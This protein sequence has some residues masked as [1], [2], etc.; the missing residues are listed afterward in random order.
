MGANRMASVYKQ[1]REYAVTHRTYAALIMPDNTTSYASKTYYAL[2]N[3]AMWFASYRVAEVGNV[4]GS[5]QFIRWVEGEPW[6]KMP[7]G[8]A[9][10]SLA[11]SMNPVTGVDL[12]DIGDPAGT[13]DI[14]RCIVSAPSGGLVSYSVPTLTVQEATNDGAGNLIV[15]NAANKMAFSINPFTGGVKFNQ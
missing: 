15:T 7:V 1:V 5:Y 11:G 9:I 10:A 3:K 8:T 4:S 12:H 6:Q 2:N 13:G 14:A